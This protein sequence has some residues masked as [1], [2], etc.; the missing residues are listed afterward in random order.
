MKPFEELMTSIRNVLLG[1]GKD[2]HSVGLF[3]P[4]GNPNGM[5]VSQLSCIV[6]VTMTMGGAVGS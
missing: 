1:H 4:Q 3:Q 6:K 2:K 5:S